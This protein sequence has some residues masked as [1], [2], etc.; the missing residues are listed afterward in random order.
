MCDAI[1][2]IVL[3]SFQIELNLNLN[4]LRDQIKLW[5]AA[6]GYE[7]RVIDVITSQFKMYAY[8][9]LRALKKFNK[10]GMKIKKY[11]TKKYSN[12]QFCNT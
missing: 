7:I 12:I 2:K 8:K 10:I 5:S 9:Y 11:I 3:Y 1:K 4:M 6:Q